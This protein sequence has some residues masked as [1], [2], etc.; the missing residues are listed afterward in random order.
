MS[1]IKFQKILDVLE[2]AFDTATK[3]LRISGGGGV[4]STTP[5]QRTPTLTIYTN[6]G[7]IAAGS[8]SVTIANTGIASGTV[9]G[10]ALAVGQTVTF[11]ANG[12]DIL[13]AITYNATGTTFLV[14]RVV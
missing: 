9:L 13:S 3:A 6:S 8:Q 11:Q 14:A 12:I 5:V 2:G 10:T 7:T 1:D 4:G